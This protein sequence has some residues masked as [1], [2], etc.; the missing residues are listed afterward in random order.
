MNKKIINLLMLVLVIFISF[1]PL[2]AQLTSTVISITGHV[3]DE[4][5]KEGLKA[6]IKIF[7]NT[8]KRINSTKSNAHEDGYYFLT[9][10]KPGLTYSV[11]IFAENYLK[12]YYTVS[13]PNTDKYIEV[14]RDF[15]LKPMQRNAKIPLTVS[16]FEYNKSKLRFGSAVALEKLANTFKNNPNV[17]FTIVS[18]PDTDAN[19][20]ENKEL[21][22]KRADALQDYF[23][24]QGIEP[25]RI[26]IKESESTDPN[27]PPPTEKR[28]KGKKYIGSTYI[29]INDF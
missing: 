28:A 15:T 13:L 24:V 5:T 1:S 9:T 26:S 25:S 14:S 22:N 21:T 10:L 6:D 20:Q 19:P 16:P 3:K 11:E 18:Y 17:K 23:I 7:D 27:I 29:I 2:S 8:G 4:I 12:E